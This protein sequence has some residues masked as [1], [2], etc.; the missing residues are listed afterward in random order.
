MLLSHTATL[1]GVFV[2]FLVWGTTACQDPGRI[3]ILFEPQI[4]ILFSAKGICSNV[5]PYWLWWD[6]GWKTLRSVWKTLWIPGVFCSKFTL[7]VNSD[8]WQQKSQWWFFV[9]LKSYPNDYVI[10]NWF[11]VKSWNSVAF[12][13]PGDLHFHQPIQVI[14]LHGYPFDHTNERMLDDVLR[15]EILGGG[16]KWLFKELESRTTSL[17]SQ[18]F[19]KNGHI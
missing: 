14:F 5:L 16:S 9:S 19:T 15:C 13:E 1:S 2:R 4:R 6:K 18:K 12:S 7:F 8:L 3:R 11:L 17:I 10:P